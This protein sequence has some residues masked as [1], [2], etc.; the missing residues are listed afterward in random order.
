MER[1]HNM[2]A[3]RINKIVSI[4]DPERDAILKSLADAGIDKKI[5]GGILDPKAAD[6]PPTCS[7]SAQNCWHCDGCAGYTKS[8]NADGIMR[9]KKELDAKGID[10]RKLNP[11]VG[12]LFQ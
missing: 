3:R 10:I 8:F 1:R 12:K 4:S 5:I 2:E 11:A 6:C 9:L 7:S